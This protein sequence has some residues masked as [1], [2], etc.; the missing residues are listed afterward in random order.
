[1]FVC[2]KDS[3]R[4]H[5]ARLNDAPS[6]Y[7]DKHPPTAMPPPR[8]RPRPHHL[9]GARVANVLV[10]LATTLIATANAESFLPDANTP[11]G[12]AMVGG[13]LEITTHALAVTA[14]VIAV[15]GWLLSSPV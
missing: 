12:P 6:L 11:T 4:H 1:M 3:L 7:D 9:L 2:P 8:R 13:G 5:V 10:A 14:G 15:F